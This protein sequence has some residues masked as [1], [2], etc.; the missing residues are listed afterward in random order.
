[1]VPFLLFATSK[2]TSHPF[3]TAYGAGL[4]FFWG[5]IYWIGFNSGA[6]WYFTWPS[7]IA[8]TL[9]LGTIWGFASW[10]TAAVSR[11]RGYWLAS[12]IF[13]TFYVVEEVFWGTG[14]FSF[15]WANWALTQ[16]AFL[17]ALQIADLGDWYGLSFWVL[18]LNALIFLQLRNH[19]RQ[20]SLRLVTAIL[21]LLPMI[22]GVVRMTQVDDTSDTI[23]VA[24]VQASTPSETKWHRSAEEIM[25]DHLDISYNLAGQDVDLIVWSETATP[26]PLRYRK[27]ART[28]LRELA[29][30]LDAV[31]V[32]GATDYKSA[33]MQDRIPYNSAF[34][35]RPHSSKLESTAKVQLVPFGERIPWQKTFPFL[36]KI[37]LGQAE[38]VPAE[39]P[40]IFNEPGCPAFGCLICF[41]VCFP[42]VAAYMVEHGAQIIAH[43]TNDGWYGDSPGPYQ[44]LYLSRLR[45]V[46]ARRSIVR[47]AN[48]GISALILPDGSFQSTLDYNEKGSLKGELPLRS[49]VTLAVKLNKIWPYFYALLFLGSLVLL[50]IRSGRPSEDRS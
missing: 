28:A 11:R 16:T 18:L 19:A 21:F 46:A 34:V 29:D 14:E 9:I 5:I 43:I 23:R 42:H 13:V 15:P 17:P 6:P 25:Q 30:S 40:T 41:E 45:A 22:Y 48:T 47:S 7:V 26:A 49:D 10:M 2:N 36:G 27:W 3:R 1:M 32:T 37:R 4:V 8:M 44:H 20:K 38:F 39:H 31:I 24:A 35:I 50:K 12:L 33:T